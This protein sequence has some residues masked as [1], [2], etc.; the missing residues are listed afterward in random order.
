M[1][2]P[3]HGFANR[4]KAYENVRRQRGKSRGTEGGTMPYAWMAFAMTE[5][6]KGNPSDNAGVAFVAYCKKSENQTG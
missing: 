3:C 4:G 2:E 5:T 1:S 6:A